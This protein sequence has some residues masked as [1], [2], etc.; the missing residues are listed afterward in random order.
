MVPEAPDMPYENNTPPNTLP[1]MA[2]L[3]GEVPE[4]VN[5]DSAMIFPGVVPVV[6]IVPALAELPVETMTLPP[7]K[8]A[9]DAVKFPVLIPSVD[10]SVILP[11]L[12]PVELMLAVS[13][14]DPLPAN[15]EIAPPRPEPLPLL[16]I[17]TPIL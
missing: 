7:L 9:V 17:G 4:L 11:P 1:A 3:P 15:K 5:A 14:I 16:E 8:L 6:L 2:I 10:T 13:V 12:C